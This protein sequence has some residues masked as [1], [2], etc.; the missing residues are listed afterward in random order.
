MLFDRVDAVQLEV[1]APAADDAR[2]QAD[3]DEILD[4]PVGEVEVGG[5]DPREV[6]VPRESGLV[7]GARFEAQHI[8]IQSGDDLDD[9]EAFFDAIQRERLEVTG[10]VQA[11]AEAHPPGVGQPEEGRAVGELE[12]ALVVGD[13]HRAVLQ[14]RIRA[15][16]G[17]DLECAV[18]AVQVGIAVVGADGV[19]VNL[20]QLRCGKAHA[21]EVVACP[22]GRNAL[23]G[24]VGVREEHVQLDVVER[25]VVGPLRDE[26]PFVDFVLGDC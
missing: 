26:G 1:V 10:P 20:P 8:G 16:I 14:Q 17:R 12:V 21:P 5:V 7:G 15:A 18:Q 9:V 22:E 24:A 11:L 19:V 13:A 25:I 4:A 3:V 23:C 6:L 2:H